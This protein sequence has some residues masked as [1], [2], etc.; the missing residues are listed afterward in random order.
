MVYEIYYFNVCLTIIVLN[1]S[2]LYI[3]RPAIKYLPINDEYGKY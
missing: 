3:C 2:I 1:F